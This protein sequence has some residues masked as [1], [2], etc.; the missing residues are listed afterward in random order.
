MIHYLILV[1]NNLDQLELLVKKIKTKNSKI[2][3]HIDKKV[4]IF[5][6]LKDVYYI[7]DRQNI[8]WWWTKMLDAELI[9]LSEIYKNMKKWDHVVIIS[10]QC[11]PIKTINYIENFINEL[12]DK[13]CIDYKI[14]SKD[15]I[16]SRI[17]GY[18]FYDVNFH[19]PKRINNILIKILSCFRKFDTNIKLPAINAIISEISSFILPKRKFLIN[20]FRIYCWSQWM[21]LS[22][23]HVSFIKDFL[24][25]DSWIKT[26]KNFKYT[27]VCDEMFFQTILWNLINHDELVNDSLW[28]INREKWAASP[29]YLTIKN[30][31]TIKKSGKLFA[32]K[33]DINIDRKILEML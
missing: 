26:K 13:S 24:E 30:L 12:L 2:Y 31:D 21:V 22:E 9:W 25:S 28:Y 1:H 19:I 23:K 16:K 11:F 29:E 33:F 20:H 7:E 32:R 3:I 6:K 4:K 27:A 18:R 5:G 15:L 14:A 17:T 10:W 8:S